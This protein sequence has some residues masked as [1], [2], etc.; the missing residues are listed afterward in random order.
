MSHEHFSE[1]PV[2]PRFQVWSDPG[3]ADLSLLGHVPGAV[4]KDCML[5]KGLEYPCTILGMCPCPDMAA[6]EEKA[7]AHRTQESLVVSGSMAGFK[8]IYGECVWGSAL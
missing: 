4:F 7:E 1:A 5:Q 6:N 3:V 8:L 2:L